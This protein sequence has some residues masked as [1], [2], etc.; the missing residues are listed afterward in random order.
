MKLTL[1]LNRKAGTLRGRDPDQV[2]EDLAEI[3][4]AHGHQVKAE[5]HSGRATIAAIARVCRER[6]CDAIVVGGGDGTISAAASAAAKSGLALGV[7]PLG[8]MN[9]F[10]RS[11]ARAARGLCR[12]QGARRGRHRQRGHRR[13]ERPLLRPPRH[14]RAASAHDP[15]P[16]AAEIRVA[17]GQDMGEHA[18]VVDGVQ[19]AAA[20]RRPHPRRRR[21]ARSGG[22]SRSSSRTIRSA[23]G[24]CRI[25][26]IS[27]RESSAS[28]SRP[29]GAGRTF[30]SSRRA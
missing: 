25:P 7:L 3:F 10:A 4:R 23:T 29:R 26:T 6:T 5:V 12:R 19:A 1:I 8:T 21:A 17:A 24:T 13:G 2:A 14:A 30:C 18:G 11:L 9:L 28:T 15:H 16:R 22:P 27:G 20:P